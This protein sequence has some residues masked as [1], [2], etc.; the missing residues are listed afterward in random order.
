[1]VHKIA[2]SGTKDWG[3]YNQGGFKTKGCKIEGVLHINYSCS[4]S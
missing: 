4:A 1:M 2:L 3:L